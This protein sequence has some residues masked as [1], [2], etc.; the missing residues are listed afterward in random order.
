MILRQEQPAGFSSG[1]KLRGKGYE[2]MIGFPVAVALAFFAGAL[3]FLSPCV[4]PLVPAYVGHLAGASISSDRSSGAHVRAVPHAV[5][6][7]LGFSVVFTGLW[8][9]LGL[10]GL[11]VADAVYRIRPLAGFALVLLGLHYSGLMPIKF[12]YREFRPQVTEPR[13][14]GLPRS[15][16]IGTLFAAGWTPCIGPALAGIIALAAGQGT[17]AE[18]S[19]LLWSYAA[20]LGLPF[21]ATAAALERSKRATRW[22][23][24]KHQFVDALA[25]GVLVLIGML[26]LSGAFTSLSTVR[27]PT[28]DV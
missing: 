21:I 14:G 9:A 28:V 17:F 27:W 16:V 2:P 26:I 20:G 12:L 4:L 13:F 18:G 1:W 3:S 8:I 11:V 7:V 24:K 10:V 6:F 22:L 23:T 15:F 19:V 25:G 5:V